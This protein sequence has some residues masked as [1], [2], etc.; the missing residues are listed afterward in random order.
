MIKSIAI[1]KA[2]INLGSLVKKVRLENHNYILEKDGFPV[3]VL[4]DIDSFE[5]MIEL[6]NSKI[7]KNIKK[8]AE[9]HKKGKTLSAFKVLENLKKI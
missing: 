1:T 6:S 8:S 9:N 4:I 2:R 3:A 7:Q 5:D